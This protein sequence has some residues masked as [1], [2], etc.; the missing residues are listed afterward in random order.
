MPLFSDAE[1]QMLSRSQ[2]EELIRIKYRLLQ[3]SERLEAACKDSAQLVPLVEEMR[4]HVARLHDLR[5]PGDS[6]LH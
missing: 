3:L 1:L 5:R 6:I 2:L 4:G